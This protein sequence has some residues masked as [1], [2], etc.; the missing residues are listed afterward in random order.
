[1]IIMSCIGFTIKSIQKVWVVP[2]RPVQVPYKVEVRARTIT[3][4]T[5]NPPTNMKLTAAIILLASTSAR[6]QEAT[7]EPGN[8]SD[9][10][11][12]EQ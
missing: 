10:N 2:A 12:I 1:M 5:T 8:F 3:H 11:K 7:Y 4:P 6:G 9:G